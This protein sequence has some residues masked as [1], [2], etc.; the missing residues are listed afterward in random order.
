MIEKVELCCKRWKMLELLYQL[1]LSNKENSEKESEIKITDI[2][3]KLKKT[4]QEISRWKKELEEM[5]IIEVREEG[6][7]KFCKLT[8]EGKVIVK[9]LKK[10]EENKLSVVLEVRKLLQ[11]LKELESI[12]KKVKERLDDLSDKYKIQIDE[13]YEVRDWGDLWDWMLELDKRKK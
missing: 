2:A 13:N 3:N 11:N 8:E 9:H 1:E 4:S 7:N 5:G 6:L 12:E 10:L